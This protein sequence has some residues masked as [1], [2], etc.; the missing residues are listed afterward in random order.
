MSQPRSFWTGLLN[1]Q[2]FWRRKRHESRSRSQRRR[3]FIFESLEQRV[4]R[5]E[6]FVYELR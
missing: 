4:P 2:G 1:R 3:Q 6:I 5:A